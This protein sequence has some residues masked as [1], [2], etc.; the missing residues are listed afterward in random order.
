MLRFPTPEGSQ[1]LANWISN[2]SSD[3]RQLPT[4]SD[5]G[6][7]ADSAYEIINMESQDDHLGASTRSLPIPEQED[8]RSLDGS[9]PQ[10]DSDSDSDDSDHPSHASSMQYAEQILRNPSPQLPLSSLQNTPTSEGSE[11]TSRSIEFVEADEDASHSAHQDYVSVT[12][13]VQ[14]FSEEETAKLAQDLEIP[15]PPKRIVE[16]IRQTMSPA[17]LSTQ[18]PL[19]VLYVGDACAQRSIILK[20]SS[21]IWVSPMDGTSDEDAFGRHREGLYNI[22]PVS[23]FGSTPE[24][25]LME[26]SHYQIKVEHCTLA[27]QKEHGTLTKDLSLTIEHDKVYTS[28]QGPKDATIWPKWTLPHI[29]LFYC[30]HE[31]SEAEE[32]TR[33]AAWEFMK[34]HGVPCIFICDSKPSTKLLAAR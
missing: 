10:Y 12:H 13:A 31:D 20:I 32:Q 21:A 29:A 34:R 24:I 14:E 15:S 19:G 18:E 6:S 17:Y 22:V 16:T 5:A 7:M 9:D 8:V 27:Y 30:R 26:A 28:L 33:D 25:D 23:T 1:H 4:M 2:S 11:E 3:I